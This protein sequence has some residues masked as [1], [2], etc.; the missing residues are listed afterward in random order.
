M[1]KVALSANQMRDYND[2]RI[3]RV[4]PD[5][6]M[7]RRQTASFGPLL[8][9][10]FYCCMTLFLIDRARTPIDHA[11]LFNEGFSDFLD[12]IESHEAKYVIIRVDSVTALMICS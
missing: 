11:K 8:T 7:A 12:V 4:P 2:C 10:V 1:I 9:A 3:F 6:T 5:R